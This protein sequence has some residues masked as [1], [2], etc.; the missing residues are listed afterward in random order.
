MFKAGYDANTEPY[1]ANFLWE[2]PLVQYV[3]CILKRAIGAV[4]RER[5]QTPVLI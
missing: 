2:R 3:Y 5:C 4:I 1:D